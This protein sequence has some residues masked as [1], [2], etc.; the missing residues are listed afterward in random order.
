MILV[1]GY[2]ELNLGLLLAEQTLFHL[3]HTPSPFWFSYFASS[4]LCFCVG[5]PGLRFSYLYSCIARMTGAG[6]N[7]Q[8]FFFIVV[9]RW[10]S[11]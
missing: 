9:L 10:V 1:G 6:Q 3:H 7:T 11:H 4:V 8:L 5:Q 2:W